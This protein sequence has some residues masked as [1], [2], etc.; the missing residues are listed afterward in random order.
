MEVQLRADRFNWGKPVEFSVVVNTEEGEVVELFQG[1]NDYLNA[2]GLFEMCKAR[3]KG[4]TAIDEVVSSIA[5]SYTFYSPEKLEVSL[6][7]LRSH[8]I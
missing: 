8:T 7:I 1:L 5:R 6:E 4:A 2:V 3:Y